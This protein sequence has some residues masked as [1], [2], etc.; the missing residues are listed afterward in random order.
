MDE[1]KPRKCAQETI[2]FLITDQNDHSPYF[3]NCP[4]GALRVAEDAED[5][6]FLTTVRANDNDRINGYNSPYGDIVYQ[7]DADMISI[8]NDGRIFLNRKLDRETQATH[9]WI[10]YARQGMKNADFLN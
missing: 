8:G 3:T 2:E 6:A 9:E 1:G 5:G 4:A 10:V 7:T